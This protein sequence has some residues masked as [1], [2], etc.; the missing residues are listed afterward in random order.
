MTLNVFLSLP[1]CACVP[2][3]RVISRVLVRPSVFVTISCSV[4]AFV[5]VERFAPV[6]LS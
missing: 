3:F 5:D 1:L 6:L 2:K 4:C